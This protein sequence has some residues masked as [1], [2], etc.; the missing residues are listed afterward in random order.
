[1]QNESL[2]DLLWGMLVSVDNMSALTMELLHALDTDDIIHR[3]IL[4][5]QVIDSSSVHSDFD[6]QMEIH[7]ED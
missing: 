7:N 5:S 1:M 2:I 4:D 3:E 6:E